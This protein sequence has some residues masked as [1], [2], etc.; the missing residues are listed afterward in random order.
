MSRAFCRVPLPLGFRSFRHFEKWHPMRD[1]D[2]NGRS[3]RPSL[4][5]HFCV[6]GVARLEHN[7]K[8]EAP[9]KKRGKR[10]SQ[11]RTSF[12]SSNIRLPP[13]CVSLIF[14]PIVQK[15]GGVSSHFC[16]KNTPAKK[17][18][19]CGARVLPPASGRRRSSLGGVSVAETGPGQACGA[20]IFFG[21]MRN[22]LSSVSCVF[23]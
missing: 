1:H 3:S 21:N 9:E 7:T 5:L 8:K 15:N 14:P 22:R 23:W 16:P 2:H 18:P 10:R 12:A 11:P 17:N 6:T 19:A 4:S 20:K 13:C